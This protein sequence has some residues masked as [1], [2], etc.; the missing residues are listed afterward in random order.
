MEGL[1]KKIEDLLSAVSFAEEGE[2]DAARSFVREGRRVL[3]AVREGQVDPRTLKY[4]LNSSLR[5]GARLDILYVSS[6]KTHDPVADPAIRQFASELQK[7]GVSYRVVPASGCMKQE[8][9]D[10]T[11]REKDILFAVIESPQSLDAECK[12]KDMRLAELW[13][14][15]KCPLVVVMKEA[16]KCGKIK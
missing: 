6:S 3:L 5:V 8:I 1:R 2:W 10:Y 11:N 14:N 7:A 13:K 16:K 4:A 12:K 15:L 9:I